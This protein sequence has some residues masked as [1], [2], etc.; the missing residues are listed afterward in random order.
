MPRPDERGV[1]TVLTAGICAV[2]LVVAWTAS[3]LVVWLGQVSAAQDA[4]DLA[5]LAAA[6][7]WAQGG[8]ACAAA[9]TAAE[10]NGSGLVACRVA[11]DQGSFVVEVRVRVALRPAL[12]GAPSGLER[13]ATAGTLQ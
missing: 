3:V 4:A 8:D 2:L 1:G 10:R 13:V 12:P 5:S 11:G 6:G 9:G 7:A